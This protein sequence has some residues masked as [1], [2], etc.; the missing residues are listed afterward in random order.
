MLNMIFSTYTP[1]KAGL[2][3]K[4]IPYSWY[5]LKNFAIPK[6]ILQISSCVHITAECGYFRSDEWSSVKSYPY[7]NFYTNVICTYFLLKPY[8]KDIY[9]VIYHIMQIVRSGKLLQLQRLVEIHGKTFVVVSFMQ[10]LLTIFMNLSLENFRS[11]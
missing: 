9:D 3:S 11:S 7:E 6:C 1:R 10:Y 4:Y 2:I 8:F 5:S